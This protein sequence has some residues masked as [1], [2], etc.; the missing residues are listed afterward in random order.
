MGQSFKVFKRLLKEELTPNLLE[1]LA[2]V[3][4]SAPFKSDFTFIGELGDDIAVSSFK[5]PKNN[6]VD[7][8]FYHDGNT[9]YTLDFS[10]NRDSYQAK[11]TQYTLKDYTQLLATVAEATSQFLQKYSPIGL[12]LIG[13]NIVSKITRR[14]SAAG[15]KDRIYK[16]FISQIEDTGNYMVDKSAKDGIAL[17]KKFTQK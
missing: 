1:V 9:V 3:F 17:V 15:Q 5:D 8:H 16:F 4:D 7:I 14:I 11:D 6:T 12:Q 13:T 10:I 2:E